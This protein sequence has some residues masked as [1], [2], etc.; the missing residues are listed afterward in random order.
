MSMPVV[1]PLPDRVSLVQLRKQAKALLAAWRAGDPEALALARGFHPR[2]DRP[3]TEEWPALADA[4]VVVAGRHGFASW[5]RLVHHLRLDPAARALQIVDRLFQSTLGPVSAPATVGEVL[6]R[7]AELMW[8][9][10]R[11]GHPA[12]AALLRAAGGARRY[13]EAVRNGLTLDQV[14]AAVAREHG[15]ADWAG[16]MAQG[17]Q[18]VDPRFEAAVDAIVSGDL[19]A[20][21]ALLDTY[22]MLVRARSPF[23]HHA[24]LVH[25][26][27]ANGVEMSR[28]WQS[29]RNAV[30][31]L[32]VLLEHGA[33]PDAVCDTYNGGSAQTPL[34]LLVSSCHPAE[35]GVQAG[36]V[37]ELCRGGAN[38]NGLDDDGLPLWTAI[39]WG[40]PAA[41]EALARS[42]ARVDNLV[43]AAALG[44]LP[45]VETCL[46]GHT[47][48]ARSGQRIGAGGPVL[49]QDHMIEYAL[50]YA[51][52]HGRREVVEFLL[53]T[54]P[55]L[56]VTEP[57]FHGTALGTA[58]YH[59]R[60]DIEA[61]L[62][63]SM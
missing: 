23:G 20:L 62:L 30:Q 13:D 2:G 32:R 34:C 29:P 45:L 33:D 35:A 28:Q 19:E 24:T 60:A 31:I 52:G 63:A 39:T 16:V 14:R 51:V 8:Q 57:V 1:L 17:D 37:G 15:F 55:D 12:A 41:A 59:G 11:D 10:H 42:G 47:G 27:A 5:A 53:T 43:F 4:Q 46:A 44:D 25:Y 9:A 38:A 18:P 48:Q 54:H 40:Y 21:R 56:N 6:T 22:P 26:I 58:R 7:R 36:L 49:N 50:I 3:P 61:L